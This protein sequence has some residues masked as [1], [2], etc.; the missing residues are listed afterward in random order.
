MAVTVYLQEWNGPGAGAPTAKNGGQ[1][2]QFKSADNPAVEVWPVVTE[3]LT[4]PNAG[5]F[6]SYEKYLKTRLNAIALP[7]VDIRNIEVFISG[8][9]PDDGT[10]IYAKKEAAYTPPLAGGYDAGG[11]MVGPKVDLFTYTSAAPLSLDDG[12]TPY[13]IAGDVGDHLVLQMEVYPTAST[14]ASSSFN[15]VLRYDETT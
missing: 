5:V 14:G 12:A 3:G 8:S 2:I 9:A 13:V 10:A 4:K 15:M 1:T 6:R 7:S 11:A